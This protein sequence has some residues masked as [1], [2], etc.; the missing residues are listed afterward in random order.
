MD[1]LVEFETN[2]KAHVPYRDAKLTHLL[3]PCLAGDAKCMLIVT[4]NTQRACLEAS[5][6]SLRLASK[7]SVIALGQ[8]K[9]NATLRGGIR[10]AI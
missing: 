6:R 7:A 8:A 5:L 9:K 4:L 10:T 3:K 2:G 1:A